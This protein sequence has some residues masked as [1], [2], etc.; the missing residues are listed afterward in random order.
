[1]NK[2]TTPHQIDRL[3]KK[4]TGFKYLDEFN[5]SFWEMNYDMNK[6][7][8]SLFI[9]RLRKIF[10]EK[11]INEICKLLLNICRECFDADYGCQCWNDE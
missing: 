7:E 4:K 10:S 8:E 11:Q 6:M 5:D 2:K 3:I 1:M 9:T